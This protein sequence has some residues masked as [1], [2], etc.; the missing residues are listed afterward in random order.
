M[1]E[2]IQPKKP[3]QQ[4]SWNYREEA[5]N[6]EDNAI[7]L[8][9][10]ELAIMLNALISRYNESLGKSAVLDAFKLSGIIKLSNALSVELNLK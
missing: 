5:N 8:T 6:V 4:V 10:N 1:N 7:G 2:S 3:L 9:N